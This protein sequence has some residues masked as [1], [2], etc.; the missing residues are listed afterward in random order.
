[1]RGY[2]RKKS[3]REEGKMEVMMCSNEEG[4]SRKRQKERW[5]RGLCR[6]TE[7]ERMQNDRE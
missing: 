5:N 6:G 7:M 3:Q 1:M 2:E 4:K